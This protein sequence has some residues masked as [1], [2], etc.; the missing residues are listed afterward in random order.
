MS[1]LPFLEHVETCRVCSARPDLLC[2]IGRKMFAEG[3]DRLVAKIGDPKR[4]K[5]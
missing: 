2:A 1:M 3:R 4:A 5:A